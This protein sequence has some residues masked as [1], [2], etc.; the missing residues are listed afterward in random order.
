[1]IKFQDIRQLS[2]FVYIISQTDFN[3]YFSD[4]NVFIEKSIEFGVVSISLE[5]Q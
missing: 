1:M 4:F 2:V 3:I 5:N